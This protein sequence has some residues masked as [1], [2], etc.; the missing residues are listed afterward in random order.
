MCAITAS[1]MRAQRPPLLS[2][3]RENSNPMQKQWRSGRVKAQWLEA[4]ASLA[5]C[6]RAAH[7]LEEQGER[8]RARPGVVAKRSGGSGG[9]GGAHRHR[10]LAEQVEQQR[11]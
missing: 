9:G 6:A 1:A 2:S 10:R 8:L 5:C 11:R 4:N 3:S 7:Q